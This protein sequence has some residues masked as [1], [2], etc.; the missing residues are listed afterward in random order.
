MSP[1]LPVS[2][3]IDGIKRVSVP[4]SSPVPPDATLRALLAQSPD[5]EISADGDCKSNLPTE[6]M[7]L[8]EGIALWMMQRIADQPDGVIHRDRLITEAIQDGLNVATVNVYL[9]YHQNF[10]GC[11]N[12]CFTV[13]GTRPTEEAIAQASRV[14][15]IQRTAS[16]VDVTV[17]GGMPEFHITCGNSVLNRGVVHIRVADRTLFPPRPIPIRCCQENFGNAQ[18]TDYGVILGL[19]SILSHFQRAHGLRAGGQLVFR[20]EDGVAIC[21]PT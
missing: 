12:D 16:G 7:P 5:L 2:E 15:A 11:G 17:S 14:A 21:D 1:R 13:V 10:R 18:T 3:I 4:R 8:P 19:S 6:A 9:G 20:I